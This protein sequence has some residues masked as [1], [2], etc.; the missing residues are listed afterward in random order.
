[1][2][3][4]FSITYRQNAVLISTDNPYLKWADGKIG[5]ISDRDF[6][7]YGKVVCIHTPNWGMVHIIFN[8]YNLKDLS[9]TPIY[10]ENGEWKVKK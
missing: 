7:Y 1:M 3:N 4:S 9:K 10:V 2:A 6:S 8:I 5:F